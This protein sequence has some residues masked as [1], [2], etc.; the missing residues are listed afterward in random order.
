MTKSALPHPPLFF[1]VLFITFLLMLPTA[2][3]TDTPKPPLTGNER[4]DAAY[5]RSYPRI[6]KTLP[7]RNLQFGSHVFIRIFKQS[8]ELELWMGNDKN[9]F[10]LYKT[11]AICHHSGVLGPK[12]EEGDRQSPE[13]FYR[14]DPGQLHP[15]S[16]YH[17]AFNL[18]YPNRYDRA[19][20]RTGG[21]L[22]I[23][24]R[25]SSIGCFAM[26]DYYMDEIYTLVNAALAS[27]QKKLEVHIFPFHLTRENLDSHKNSPWYSFW[28]NLKEGYDYFENYRQPPLVDV[29]LKRYV[30]STPVLKGLAYKSKQGSA[31]EFLLP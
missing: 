4:T 30:F 3:A 11:F 10:V 25:C 2:R 13:G 21:A 26:T 17:L 20:D 8:K 1:P 14:V 19:H 23:H 29:Q 28:L 5:Q 12:I 31:K 24:G 9:R 7:P 15:L 6:M 22:M 16:E 18:G 27:G